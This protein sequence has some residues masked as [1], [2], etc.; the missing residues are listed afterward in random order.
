MDL[1]H[2]GDG[3]EKLR[4]V[5]VTNHLF[6]SSFELVEVGSVENKLEKQE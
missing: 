1:I 2:V 5:D 4:V 6:S 3:G